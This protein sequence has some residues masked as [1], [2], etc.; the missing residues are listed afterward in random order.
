MARRNIILTKQTM[1]ILDELPIK[2]YVHFVDYL[3]NPVIRHAVDAGESLQWWGTTNHYGAW[4]EVACDKDANVTI[5]LWEITRQN[6]T[7][8][9]ADPRN[10]TLAAPLHT[11]SNGLASVEFRRMQG[12]IREMAYAMRGAAEREDFSLFENMAYWLGKHVPWVEQATTL[13]HRVHP[14][15]AG[16]HLYTAL[17]QMTLLAELVD[18]SVVRAIASPCTTAQALL[19]VHATV[20][21]AT[22]NEHNA[23]QAGLYALESPGNAPMYMFVQ[24]HDVDNDGM[25][26][27]NGAH[28]LLDHVCAPI[29]I[30]EVKA[31]GDARFS[32]LVS[33]PNPKMAAVQ[34][35]PQGPSTFGMLD[36]LTNW[37][38]LMAQGFN[39]ETSDLCDQLAASTPRALGAAEA[40]AVVHN[41]MSASVSTTAL[42]NNNV[43]KV[44][45][46]TMVFDWGNKSHVSL[47]MWAT[48]ASSLWSMDKTKEHAVLAG[49][50]PAMDSLEHIEQWRVQMKA[51]NTPAN[52]STSESYS[53]VGLSNTETC[54]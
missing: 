35:L 50:L 18:E 14:T 11:S 52:V 46:T 25:H 10:T 15:A 22:R 40:L 38:T 53:M 41:W 21:A 17:K 30:N 33:H 39:P 8:Q 2:E 45:R 7:P 3:N 48:Y 6:G 19:A 12:T 43:S 4:V 37:D 23:T 13:A 44:P 9:K 27:A 26:K 54:A 49:L 34:W 1:D 42:W 28:I 16:P 24:P 20:H 31:A 47:A 32:D 5:Q 29:F 36:P 51:L